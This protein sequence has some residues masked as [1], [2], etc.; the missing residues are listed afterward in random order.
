MS[1]SIT[2]AKARMG[3]MIGL[4]FH[5]IDLGWNKHDNL[6]EAL[7]R[8]EY[9]DD[10]VFTIIG[11]RLQDA[12][13]VRGSQK[14]LKYRGS[15]AVGR[16]Y[17]EYFSNEPTW[18]PLIKPPAG[19]N[20]RWQVGLD[21]VKINGELIATNQKALIDTG[22]AFIIGPEEKVDLIR[23]LMNAEYDGHRI[24]F[25]D[26]YYVRN[27]AFK[28]GGREFHLNADDI[29]IENSA[30][31]GLFSGIMKSS[32]GQRWKK[33]EWVLG[34]LFVDNMTTIFDMFN[35]RSGEIDSSCGVGKVQNQV[36]GF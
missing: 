29:A 15:L 27:I 1:K 26:R 28:F 18:C 22:T 19:E 14:E 25:P 10:A 8:Q 24:R 13:K 6:I 23:Q 9:I 32:Q 20:R 16:V 31:G 30:K 11:P 12:G 7:S 33:D 34:G 21:E 17:R 35:Y 3:G 4:G 2:K 36:A 5:E